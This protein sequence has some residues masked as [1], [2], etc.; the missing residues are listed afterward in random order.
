[1]RISLFA[2]GNG[3]N[4]K[5]IIEHFKNSKRI[6][7]VLI[8]TNN[9]NAKVISVAKQYGLPF[10]IANKDFIYSP[11]NILKKLNKHQI[12]LICLAG[13]LKLIPIDIINVFPNAIINIHPSLLPKYGGKGMYGINVHNAVFKNKEKESGITIHYVNENFDEGKMIFQKSCDMRHCKN[14][15]EIAKEV[16]KLEHKYYPLIIEELL[17][18]GH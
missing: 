11:K 13:F 15:D 4:V 18:K 10:Q 7:V 6:K 16:Q 3:S 14:P 5:K 12:D 2:S 8:I 1:M 9:I 17:S